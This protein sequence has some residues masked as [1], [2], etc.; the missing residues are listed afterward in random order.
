MTFG[1]DER[2]A[3]FDIT[4]VENQFILEYMTGAKGEYVKVYLYGLLCCYHPQGKMDLDYI[5]RELGM[6]EDEV[7]TAFRYW[8]KRRLVRRISDKPPEWQYVNIKQIS[9]ENNDDPEPDY[10]R[11]CREIENSLQ[12]IR[13]FHGSETAACY[14]WKE[15]MGL[16]TE[17]IILLLRYMARTRGKHFRIKDA[18]K[19]AMELSDEKAFTVDEA[20]QFLNRDEAM[21]TGFRKILRKMGKR[22]NPSDANLN[23]YRKWVEDWKF[24]Q[25][26][27]EEAC[28]RTGTSDPSLALVDAILEQTYS[29]RGSAGKMLDRSDLNAYEEERNQLKEVLNEV[30]QY[31]AVTP[32]QQKQY[33]RMKE[34]YPQR[35]ILIA[36]RE[37]AAKQKK[38]DSV[39]KLLESWKERGFT[40]EK[41]I[42][43]HIHAFHDKE[44]YLMSLRRKWAGKDADV[45]Q[46]AL[47]LLDKWENELGFSREMIT[48]AADMA[49]EVRKPVAYMDKTLSTWAENGIRTPED[50]QK[51]AIQT[52]QKI[53]DNNRKTIKT[54][55]AQ[56]YTQRDYEGEQE[57][58]MQRMLSSLD[59]SKPDKKGEGTDA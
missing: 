31:G 44:E 19:I 17:I 48:L 43:D 7:Q 24:T 3:M 29:S 18:E 30:G 4:P 33:S 55:S 23:L 34:L 50:V 40:E 52:G 56:H 58:A 9:L 42:R 51:H 26:A 25:A 8:E 21:N 20:E 59:V 28:D 12:D 1:F 54:V 5:A 14:E 27:I 39:L 41:Q 38:F 16:S 13:V 49:F 10:V 35:I 6:T 32:A 22:Y 37:C 47:Q 2:F 46:K 36:A 53:P 45:G 11:F 15:E 57:E